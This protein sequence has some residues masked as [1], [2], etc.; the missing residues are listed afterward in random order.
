MDDEAEVQRQATQARLYARHALSNAR[1]EMSD[2]DD[3]G[4][5][6]DT[7]DDDD[8]EDTDTG[9]ETAEIDEGANIGQGEAAA[10][11]GQGADADEIGVG[12]DAVEIDQG[13]IIIT[14]YDDEHGKSYSEG[15]FNVV[16]FRAGCKETEEEGPGKN[17]W[18]F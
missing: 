11:I 2:S 7:G 6:T 10:E 13:P 14:D 5:S 17:C 12:I 9:D 1:E 3:G 4:E 18:L 15:W 16:C 8:G